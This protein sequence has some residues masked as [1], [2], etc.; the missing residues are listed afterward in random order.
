M[1]CCDIAILYLTTIIIVVI[2]VVVVVVNKN[3]LTI[4]KILLNMCVYIMLLMILPLLMWVRWPLVRRMKSKCLTPFTNF[5]HRL[6]HYTVYLNLNDF[7]DRVSYSCPSEPNVKRSRV[8]ATVSMTNDYY[9][10][11]PAWLIKVI[12]IKEATNCGNHYSV[13]LY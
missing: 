4:I 10:I 7:V 6:C 1:F 13:L 2:V 11:C 5:H 3:I 12:K 9:I 8:Q